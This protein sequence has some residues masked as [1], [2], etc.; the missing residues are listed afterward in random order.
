MS[1]VKTSRITIV[2]AILIGLAS[3]TANA[4]SV[5]DTPV[6]ADGQ[7]D[8]VN[9]YHNEAKN[10]VGPG[11]CASDC[12]CDG[13][14]SCVAGKCTGTP[15]PVKLTAETCNTKDYRYQELWT[16][17][18]PGKCTGDCECDGLRTCTNGECTG[19]AR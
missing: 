14:R 11:K 6:P 3:M 12:D 10:P 5:K 15:R 18:G 9:F 2:S 1:T 19:T 7:C 16:K 17:A 8:F 13:M 4:K